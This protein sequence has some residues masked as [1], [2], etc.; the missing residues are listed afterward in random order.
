MQHLTCFEGIKKEFFWFSW[1][2][3]RRFATAWLYGGIRCF[4]SIYRF[5]SFLIPLEF[6]FPF[7]GMIMFHCMRQIVLLYAADH[8]LFI[9][10]HELFTM[11]V[12]WT[13]YF[14]TGGTKPMYEEL[15][16]LWYPDL[17]SQAG[18]SSCFTDLIFLFI[19][20][21]WSFNVLELPISDSIVVIIRIQPVTMY[22]SFQHVTISKHISELISVLPSY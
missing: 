18:S 22:S 7:T 3:G 17:H 19:P 11:E 16:T 2:K 5:R 6:F 15:G 10:R 9:C 1:G 21:W 13:G 4:Y 8:I 14:S 12:L 20:P